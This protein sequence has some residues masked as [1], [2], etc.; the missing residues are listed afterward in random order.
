MNRTLMHKV[1]TILND[2]VMENC[3]WGEVIYYAAYLYS[4]TASKEINIFTWNEA[5]TKHAPQN[6]NINIFGW[7]ASPTSTKQIENLSF[8][9]VQKWACLWL[10]FST[11]HVPYTREDWFWHSTYLSMRT[12]SSKGKKIK[13]SS[14]RDSHVDGDTEALSEHV[15]V[16]YTN[17][18]TDTEGS[19]DQDDRFD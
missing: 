7:A 12:S 10:K 14:E 11:E 5:L 2:A 15:T 3:Y 6:G 9:I 18:A 4:R 17:P 8:M 1:R 16:C 13:V 19:I